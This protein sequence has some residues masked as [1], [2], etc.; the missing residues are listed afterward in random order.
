MTSSDK[1]TE[2]SPFS[3]EGLNARKKKA[4]NVVAV[5]AVS[6]F[7][8]MAYGF[9]VDFLKNPDIQTSFYLT[10]PQKTVQKNTWIDPQPPEKKAAPIQNSSENTNLIQELE[11]EKKN[12]DETA[13][14]LRELVEE[15]HKKNADD[16]QA[17]LPLKPDIQKLQQ[18]KDLQEQQKIIEIANLQKQRDEEQNKK[19]NILNDLEN[20]LT[21]FSAEVSLKAP[22]AK[23]TPFPSSVETNVNPKTGK[24]VQR[25]NVKNIA[26]SEPVT[27]RISDNFYEYEVPQPNL[28]QTNLIDS[29]PDFALIKK[30]MP[31]NAI[32]LHIITPLPE[33]LEDSR[34]GKLP[35]K[36]DDR[37]AFLAY[38]HQVA[39]P[40]QTPYIAIL[41]SGL[42]KRTNATEAAI[43]TLP[44][45]VSLSF[46]PYADKLTTYIENARK[47][48]HETLLDLPMQQGVF[49]DTD[50]G[51]LGLVSGLPEQENRKRLH[52][53]LG[54]NVAI[55]GI[56]AA[57]KEN[58][59]YSGSQMKPFYEEILDRGLIYIN[60]TDDPRMPKF[61]KALRPDVHIAEDFHRAAIRA[62]LEQAKQIALKKGAAFVRV[63][64]VP[65]TLLVV[66]EWM[67]SFAPTEEK[68]VA[69]ISF[70]PLSYYVQQKE[71]QK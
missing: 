41:F 13:V 47:T 64:T 44:D 14:V 45:T 32:P 7:L 69:E 2:Q 60:G 24:D 17:I 43:N 70:V 27:S 35:V 55:I 42:G 6:S 36:K 12:I 15:E 54:Q 18:E 52:K 53:V 46:S 1:K 30:P 65:I 8:C 59:S 29:L 63:E 34:Y 51:P 19:I 50:P 71:A 21:T 48:G 5:L 31:A 67:K 25:T 28:I 61:P 33:L 39:L 49:P 11:K 38:S 10:N 58:F 16:K 26:V 23:N 66:E 37:S 4:F 62:R 22:V 68:P 20:A 56:T 40:P 9:Y 57:S 3:N